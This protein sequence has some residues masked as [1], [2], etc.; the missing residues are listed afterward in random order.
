MFKASI[1]GS[2]AV[3]LDEEVCYFN[4][5]LGRQKKRRTDIRCLAPAVVRGR[6]I[7]CRTSLLFLFYLFY[8]YPFPTSYSTFFGRFCDSL[9]HILLLLLSRSASLPL[10]S[11][12]DP[13][14]FSISLTRLLPRHVAADDHLFAFSFF[15][16]NPGGPGASPHLATSPIHPV[17]TARDLTFPG[18]GKFPDK[19]D[20]ATSRAA[21]ALPKP[22]S[23]SSKKEKEKDKDKDKDTAA[24]DDVP[25][26]GARRDSKVAHP[27]PERRAEG[28]PESMF[29]KGDYVVTNVEIGGAVPHHGEPSYKVALAATDTPEKPSSKRKK[30]TAV[31]VAVNHA[32]DMQGIEIETPRKEPEKKESEKKRKRQDD[33]HLPHSVLEEKLTKQPASHGKARPSTSDGLTVQQTPNK[34]GARKRADSHATMVP[35][36]PTARTMKIEEPEEEVPVAEDDDADADAEDDG[37][38]EEDEPVYCYCQQVSYGEMVACDAENCPREWYHLDCVGLHQA[39]RGKGMFHFPFRHDSRR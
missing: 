20:A 34:R 15:S 37:E 9:L 18:V 4:R 2:S 23:K 17:F 11:P 3:Q 26:A 1:E 5:V 38:G 13:P 12:T 30:D 7:L 28:F 16:K 31:P 21:E 14:D 33:L 32:D 35:A 25:A 29:K 10:I 36:T 19:H 8:F 22:A 27:M 24:R 6:C 39:P